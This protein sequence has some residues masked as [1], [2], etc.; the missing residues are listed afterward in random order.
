MIIDT[1]ATIAFKCSSCGTFEFFNISLFKL[2]Y[3]KE[4][5]FR[6]RCGNSS[7]Q[8][9]RKNN[10]EYKLSMPCLS[11]GGRHEY[12]LTRKDLISRDINVF[13]CTQTGMQQCFIGCDDDVLNRIDTLERELDELI[14]MFGYDSYFKNT[15]VMIDTLNR[16]HDIAEQGN[17]YCECGNNDIELLLFP[18]R[19][20]LNCRLC[21][22]TKV[23]NAGS[24]D[25]LKDILH[26]HQITLLGAV[27]KRI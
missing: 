5:C 8:L 4:Y 27:S 22:G 1:G 21:S 10:R 18:D 6:C 23:I 13:Y 25:D 20:E 2:L 16:I 9:T 14:D 17:L 24:N 11:C 7:L 26:G 3:K 19:V 15:R 12:V